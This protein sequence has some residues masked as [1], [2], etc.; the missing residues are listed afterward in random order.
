MA[1]KTVYPYGTEGRLPSSVGIVNDFKTGGADKALSAEAGKNFYGEVFGFDGPVDL[2]QLTELAG[3]IAENGQGLP[4]WS[5]SGGTCV[6]LPVTPGREYTIT[7]NEDYEANFAFLK[8][9]A[10][11]EHLSTPLF[12]SGYSG[13]VKPSAGTSVTVVAP[14]D[15]LTLYLRKQSSAGYNMLPSSVSTRVC[16][17]REEIVQLE[18]DTHYFAPQSLSGLTERSGFINDLGKW[19][20]SDGK[21]VCL[22]I[23]PGKSYR[24]VAKDDVQANI[25][26]LAENGTSI[27]Q[28]K[29]VSFA[30]GFNGR[31][32]PAAGDSYSF[33]APDDAV[34]LYIRTEASNGDDMTPSV[35]LVDSI[36]S[37]LDEVR[38][39]LNGGGETREQVNYSSQTTLATFIDATPLWKDSTSYNCSILPVNPGEIYAFERGTNDVD[40]AILKTNGHTNNTIPDFSAAFTNRIMAVDLPERITIPVDGHYLYVRKKNSSGTCNTKIYKVTTYDKG[41]IERVDDIDAELEGIVPKLSFQRKSIS[42]TTGIIAD[43]TIRLLSNLVLTKGRWRVSVNDGYVIHSITYYDKDGLFIT[44]IVAGTQTAVSNAVDDIS[45]LR[46]VVRKEDS[47]AE[48]AVTDNFGF[49]I[50]EVSSAVGDDLVIPTFN[51]SYNETDTES[52]RE[53]VGGIINGKGNIE[54]FLFFTDPHLTPNSRYETMTELIRDKF[55]STLQKYYNSLPLDTVICGG[56]WLNFDHSNA[57]AAGWLGYCDGYM[58][59]LFRNYLPVFGNHD[60][61]PYNPDTSSSNWLKALTYVDIRNLM[62]RENKLTYY[63]HEAVNTRFYILNSGVS[64]IKTMTN[65][66]YSRLVSNRWPQV[67]WLGQKLLSEDPAHGVIVFHIYSNATNE[68]EWFSNATGYWAKGIHAFGANVKA[69]AIAYN[70]RQSITLNGNTYDFSNCEGNIAFIMCGHTHFDY[71]DTSEELPIV[72]CTN[73]EGGYLDG[74]EVKYTLEPTFDNCV[75]DYDNGVLYMVRIGAAKSRII[76]FVPQTLSVGSTVEL[77]TELTGTVT[78]ASRDTSKAMVSNGTVTGVAAGVVGIKASD[79]TTE[80]Y[81]IIKVS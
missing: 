50:S 41:L 75:V 69:M 13:R 39:E 80:E 37:Y 71:V 56:D 5:S 58:R 34:T 19:R 76:H 32:I 10:V 40:I 52:I 61:N 38:A 11:G 46:F 54:T 6:L 70:N 44:G 18:E 81:W 63:S 64:F 26:V 47:S 15:A 24:V 51:S 36:K 27:S 8:Q 62:F 57:E 55:I 45:Y 68:S 28:N 72:C 53:K 78:W 17:L 30:T 12:A 14:F 1:N 25:A 22:P 60:N 66:D 49:K 33:V 16:G 67:D 59:K 74:S 79:D 43:S 65:S 4:V 42:T 31:I 29:D 23:V 3:I 35:Y 21:Y 77:D 7:A 20:T 2:S 48:I 73:L 9:T